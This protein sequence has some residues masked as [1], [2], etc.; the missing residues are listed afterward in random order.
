MKEFFSTNTWELPLFVLHHKKTQ[1]WMKVVVLYW[2]LLGCRLMSN[3]SFCFS[4]GFEVSLEEIF[5]VE[6][7]LFSTPSGFL[8]GRLEFHLEVCRTYRLSNF[9]I[10]YAPSIP[11]FRLSPPIYQIEKHHTN[12]YVLVSAPPARAIFSVTYSTIFPVT[13]VTSKSHSP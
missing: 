3:L 1:F 9:C 11:R 5:W 12:S 7:K 6:W 8:V 10:H 4:E 2:I 13:Q